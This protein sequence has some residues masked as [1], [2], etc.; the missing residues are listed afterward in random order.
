MKPEIS[1]VMSTY[2][3]STQDLTKAIDSMLNQTFKNFE[4]IIIL[5]NG[6]CC[7]R[8]CTLQNW[9]SKRCKCTCIRGNLCLY[10]HD[11]SILITAHGHI[12][13]KWMPLGM[14]KQGLRSCKL[15]LNRFLRHI[16]KKCA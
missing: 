9:T 3:E 2:N 5:D 13:I 11:I 14:N 12:H 6:P 1:I 16:S 15:H 8:A 4:F 7:V 10:A